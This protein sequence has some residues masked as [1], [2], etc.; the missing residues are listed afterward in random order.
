[1][2]EMNKKYN[3][4][5]N[6]GCGKKYNKEWTN[7]D[8]VSD[9]P[10]VTRCS[11]IKGIPFKDN[12][13]DVVY[14]SQVLEHI[15]KENAAFFMKECYRVLKPNGVI[16]V[17]VPD[18][19]NIAREYLKQLDACIS[20][21]T[22]LQIKNYEWMVLEIYDQS[23]RNKNGGE[24]LK[25]FSEDIINKDYIISRTGLSG[26]MIK[27][28]KHQKTSFLE[29]AKKMGLFQFII[30]VFKEIQNKILS[31][32]V[33]PKYSVGNFRLSGEVHNWM[34][35]RFSLGKLMDSVGFVNIEIA[36]PEKSMIKDWELHELDVK[37]GKAY[38]PTSL[39]MEGKKL[40]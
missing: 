33:G 29:K 10:H 25:Y 24:M 34:Y 19:E 1:M 28:K 6:V 5:L 4:Y 31:F 2:N 11:L 17:V 32:L 21:P 20:N 7:I 37:N 26:E 22:D 30:R 12:T 27:D 40:N 35:D 8:M 18:L 39:F 3:N 16:R 15:P 36:S 23:V 9:S 14:H 13:F 38:D